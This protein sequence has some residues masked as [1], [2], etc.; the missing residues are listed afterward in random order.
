[1]FKLPETASIPVPLYKSLQGKYFVGYAEN[2]EFTGEGISAWSGLFNPPNSGVNLHVNVWTVTSLYGIF[3][4]QIWFNASLPGNPVR[5][6]LVTPSNYSITP[7]PKPKVKL[8]YAQSVKGDPTG[9]VKAFVR[10]G[11]AESTIVAEE[12]GKFIF[13]PGGSFTVFL[14][15]PETPQQAASGRIAFGWW[16]E[17]I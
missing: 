4:A 2:L 12:D 14:S 13:P 8:L 17:P 11:E 16:E 9:G 10:R 6:Q 3:R 15:N 7:L 5:S 1:L